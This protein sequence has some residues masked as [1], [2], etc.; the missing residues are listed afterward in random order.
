[1]SKG[2]TREVDL[3][4]R[5]LQSIAYREDNDIRELVD[6]IIDEWR[7]GLKEGAK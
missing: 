5:V 7:S 3:A 4:I 2:M 1:V 6:D